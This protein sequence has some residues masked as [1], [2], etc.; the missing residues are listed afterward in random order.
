M[1]SAHYQRSNA[2]VPLGTERKNVAAVASQIAL[3]LLGVV[4][5]SLS[6]PSILSDTGWFPLAFVALIPLFMVVHR[7]NWTGIVLYGLLYGFATYSVLNYW[8]INFHPLAI[9]VVPVIYAAYLAAVFPLLKL[10]DTLFPRYGYLLQIAIWL[11]YEYLRLQGFLGYAYGI[12]GYSQYLFTPLIQI[13]SVTGVWGVSLLVVF[14]SAYLGNALSGGRQTLPSFLRAHRTDAVAYGFLFV[15]ALVFGFVSQVDYSSAPRWRVAMVQQNVDPWRGGLPAYRKSLDILMRQSDSALSENPDIIVWSETSFVPS[16]QY[17]AR[18]RSDP[19]SYELVKELLEYLGGQQV[20]F[21]I[22]NGDGVLKRNLNGSLERVDYNA[23]LLYD[24]GDIQRTYRKLRLVPF[25]EHFPYRGALSWLYRLLVAN[26]TTFWE[27]GDEYTIFDAAGVKFATPICFED[28]FGY[29]S[30][31]FVR[32]GAQVI[33]NLTNDSWS[34]SVP[35]EMQHMAMAVFR[36]VENR[37]SMV[38]S[39]NGGITTAIDPNG[40]IMEMFP[41]FV[42]GYMVKDVP[43][44]TATGTVYTSWGNW[45]AFL[46]LIV[47]VGGLIVGIAARLCRRFTGAN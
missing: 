35:A 15:A 17:H 26:N 9:F 31:N 13:A 18:Y 40:H 7:S 20:P 8:L 24:H 16:I 28:T 44:Y 22:G 36:T 41:P 27:A 5:Y 30:R 45:F 11:S 2:G 46:A 3:L 6:F 42:E 14:P 33:V 39:T 43:V 23:V 32:H 38:R 47:S 37:R 25:T 34:Y 4:L 1:K 19:A 29:L 21:V 10:A 12:S